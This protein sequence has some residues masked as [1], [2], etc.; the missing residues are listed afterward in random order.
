MAASVPSV[1]TAGPHLL[2]TYAPE[3]TK[4]YITSRLECVPVVVG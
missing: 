1:K 2:G 4:V 3:I